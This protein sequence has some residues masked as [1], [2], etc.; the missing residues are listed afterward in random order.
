VPN[1]ST[2]TQVGERAADRGVISPKTYEAERSRS[3]A[4]PSQA[5]VGRRRRPT[6][7]RPDVFDPGGAAGSAAD[8]VAD[9]AVVGYE[10]NA[11]DLVIVS[12]PEA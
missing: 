10:K 9:A 12:R 3:S 7:L 8:R 5:A 4:D 2:Q 1:K 11:H 6:P